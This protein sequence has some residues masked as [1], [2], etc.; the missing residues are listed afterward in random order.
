MPRGRFRPTIEPDHHVPERGK[1]GRSLSKR[2]GGAYLHDTECY[3][4]GHSRGISRTGTYRGDNRQFRTNLG[5][6][7][8]IHLRRQVQRCV[9][10]MSGWRCICIPHHEFVPKHYLRSGG[11]VRGGICLDR[12][13]TQFRGYQQGGAAG[14]RYY[15]YPGNVR[16]VFFARHEKHWDEPEYLE[17]PM[18]DA[19]IPETGEG[20]ICY[21]T[22]RG[23]SDRLHRHAI[24]G[25]G[26]PAGQGLSAVG[27]PDSA[28]LPAVCIVG[29][30]R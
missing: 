12:C 30:G 4:A 22:R 3:R 11:Q 10:E 7:V 16:L 29:R 13:R 21:S 25:Q 28:S 15:G 19:V 14:V 17:K 23:A 1:A 8:V 26:K 20:E 2:C 5:R 6:F 18:A 9:V 24:F 27:K